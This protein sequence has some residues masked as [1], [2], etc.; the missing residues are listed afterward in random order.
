MGKCK[1]RTLNRPIL[2][3][4]LSRE[5]AIVGIIKE[6][7]SNSLT[8]ESKKLLTLFGILPEELTEAGASYEEV[9]I[10]KRHM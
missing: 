3:A 9:L 10:L 1:K 8:D 5:E 2:E 6:I 4:P 7:K